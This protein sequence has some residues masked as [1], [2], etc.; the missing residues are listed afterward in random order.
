MTTLTN[1][2]KG[3][4]M[5]IY[6]LLLIT[7]SLYAAQH[8]LGILHAELLALS[9]KESAEEEEDLPPLI[10]D[11]IEVTIP[12]EHRKLIGFL[13]Q[14]AKGNTF[15]LARISATTGRIERFL[16]L[17]N[18]TAPEKKAAL[19]EKLMKEHPLELLQLLDLATYLDVQPLITALTEIL[20]ENMPALIARNYMQ[21]ILHSII[22]KT[23]VH[24]PAV[25]KLLAARAKER[26]PQLFQHIT[27]Q[28]I[29]TVPWGE[30][31]W[32]PTRNS[33]IVARANN[34]TL[35]EKENAAWKE[36]TLFEEKEEKSA[37]SPQLQQSWSFAWHPQG[38]LLVGARYTKIQNIPSTLYFWDRAHNQEWRVPT[39]LHISALAWNPQGTLLALG[40]TGGIEIRTE[41]G[42]QPKEHQVPQ[43]PHEAETVDWI[44]WGPE[45]KSLAYRRYSPAPSGSGVNI[46]VT[47]IPSTTNPQQIITSPYSF[48][49]PAINHAHNRFV[50]TYA[51]YFRSKRPSDYYFVMFDLQKKAPL[52]I[53]HSTGRHYSSP[54]WSP[55]DTL[56]AFY[57][58]NNIDLWKAID[59]TWTLVKQIPGPS[60]Y[61]H[62]ANNNTLQNLYWN[63]DDLMLQ[64]WH[65][66]GLRPSIEQLSAQQLLL[67]LTLEHLYT[68]DPK[69]LAS[70][71]KEHTTVAEALGTFPALLQKFIFDRYGL[72]AYTKI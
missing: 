46:Y 43:L 31:H 57:G 51:P 69:S 14:D 72:Q 53:A 70:L 18:E 36:T 71:I 22:H 38:A 30:I 10:P 32:H 65:S 52:A 6:L 35:F 29:K 40:H 7:G 41:Q 56:L 54:A 33:F 44:T 60:G 17:L 5:L 61:L 16:A 55:D 11:T 27:T 49:I 24:N 13:P 48:N 64:E 12:E 58:Q 39:N 67:L 59:D 9:A 26:H 63:D 28:K 45:G 37:K 34:V 68:N 62:F 42:E 2:C 21:E 25:T 47:D 3:L 8:D 23:V 19:K 15:S 1:K 20:V 4:C 66:E 50:Y